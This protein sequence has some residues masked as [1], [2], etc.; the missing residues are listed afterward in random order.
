MV[1]HFIYNGLVY[2]CLAVGPALYPDLFARLSYE[3]VTG[4][5]YGL[6]RAALAAVC[7]LA[8]GA[9]LVALARFRQR[10]ADESDGPSRQPPP[11][12]FARPDLAGE[13]SS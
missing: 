3:E 11:V 7:L 10:P 1:F 9:V 12:G 5:P 6:T 13:S 8:A 4:A 2:A